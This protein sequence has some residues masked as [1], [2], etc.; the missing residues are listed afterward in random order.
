MRASLPTVRRRRIVPVASTAVAL[1]ALLGCDPGGPVEPGTVRELRI[2]V[3]ADTVRPG[4]RFRATALALDA[5]GNPQDAPVAWRSL[6]PSVLDVDF[7]GNV[8][9]LAPGVGVVRASVG[10]LVADRALQLVNPPAATVDFVTDTLTLTLPGSPAVLAV[11]ARDS[12]GDVLVGAPVLLETEAAR[13]ATVSPTGVVTPVAVGVTTLSASLDTVRRTRVVRVQAAGGGTAPQVDLVEPA[14]ITPGQTFAIR[15]RRFGSTAAAVNVAVDG[16]PAALLSVSDTLLTATLPLAG[17]PCLP[18]RGVAVQV[19]TAGGVGA[20]SATLQVAPQRSLAPGQALVLSTAAMSSC[21]ELVVG[22]GRYLAALLNAG[23]TLGAGSIAVN[24]DLRGGG[25][26]PPVTLRVD[27]NAPGAAMAA[28]RQ[29]AAH[30]ARLEASRAAVA[31]LR[32]TAASGEAALQVPEVGGITTLRVPDL[33]SE[34]FCVDFRSIHARTVYRGSQVAILED[35]ATTAEF[36][37]TLAQAMDDIILALG[38]EIEQVIWPLLTPLGNPLVMDSRLD[39]NG[40]VTVVL[41]PRL[42]AMRDGAVLGA[43][44]T[45]DFFPQT[46]LPSSNVGEM[47]YLQVPTSAAAGLAP[48]SRERWRHEMRGTVAHELRHVAAYAERIVRGQP[49]EETWLDEAIARHVEE[50]FTRAITG[51][52]P[53]GDT[54]YASI[55]CEARVLRGDASCAEAPRLMRPHFDG[56]YRYLRASAARSPLGPVNA[57]DESFYGSGWSLLRWALDHAPSGTESSLL[58]AMTVNGASGAAN[59]EAQVGR[60]WS[61]ILGRW[62]LALLLEAQGAAPAADPTLRLPSWN[63][64]SVFAGFCADLGGCGGGGSA[65]GVFG[66]PVPLVPSVLPASDL[67]LQVANLVPGGF[68]ALEL[69]PAAPGSRRL[70]RLR[71][72]GGAALPA[73]VRIAVVRV[74]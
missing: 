4:L 19:N 21:N 57:D 13:I 34:T 10:A 67:T 64:G 40:L 50:R 73:G 37:P 65:Q 25:G 58:Q 71:T 48:G 22:E 61:D 36:G 46:Q 45:C 12:A 2:L 42:N 62:S 63:L 49:L 35:T 7:R 11:V 3:P 15:G 56:L 18:T 60:T 17:V 55:A 24:L 68:V 51:A 9:V 74:E 29:P 33:D 26:L 1:A 52:L 47:V 31:G 43:V 39:D 27:G 6:T 41:T 53:R 59:V 66:R 20:G 44:V 16:L 14:S 8:Q 72:A 23:R 32:W 5:A 30:Q 38:N 70:L 69:L 54:D 28:I